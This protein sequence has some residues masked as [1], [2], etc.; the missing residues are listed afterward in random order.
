MLTTVCEAVGGGAAGDVRSMSFPASDNESDDDDDDEVVPVD[1]GLTLVVY[2]CLAPPRSREFKDFSTTSVE[3]APECMGVN[4]NVKEAQD[5]IKLYW[6]P[7]AFCKLVENGRF[8]IKWGGEMSWQ[9]ALCDCRHPSNMPWF[10]EQWQLTGPYHNRFS[11]LVMFTDVCYIPV[12]RLFKWRVL[13]NVARVLCASRK[14]AQQRI[15]ER[16]YAPGGAGY[17]AARAHFTASAALQ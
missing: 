5:K 17:E 4:D 9:L 16:D 7:H 3:Y 14:R 11:P 2:H 6:P 12:G 10:D 1:D 15:T 13:F 8:A